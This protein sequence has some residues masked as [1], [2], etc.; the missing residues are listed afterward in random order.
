MI[1]GLDKECVSLVEI[2]NKIDGVATI[3]SCCGHL[4]AP[5]RIW[6]VSNSFSAVGI[7]HRCVD[8]RYSD[9][10]WKIEVDCS[11]RIPTNGFLLTSVEPFKTDSEMAES[12][13]ALIKNILYWCGEEFREYF[14]ELDSIDDF[15]VSVL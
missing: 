4:T 14:K 10:K 2:L 12:V 11:D 7:L 8:K 3:E 6:F 13:D 1:I 9:G 15:K 5:Y